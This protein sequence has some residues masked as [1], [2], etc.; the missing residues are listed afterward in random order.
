MST[1]TKLKSDAMPA[2]T[3]SAG[4]VACLSP[5]SPEKGRQRSMRKLLSSLQPEKKTRE[6]STA[7]PAR[8]DTSKTAAVLGFE[9]RDIPVLVAAGLLT[10][11]AN[12]KQ[13]SHKYFAACIVEVLAQS[14]EW[15]NLATAAIYAYWQG[16]NNRK[17]GHCQRIPMALLAPAIEI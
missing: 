8:L 4:D 2:P 1:T 14:V 5:H 12:P 11:L 3:E 6:L 15:L 9:A 13:N 17:N 7:M 10:P 16:K